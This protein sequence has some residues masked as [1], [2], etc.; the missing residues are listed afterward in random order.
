MAL[1]AGLCSV[2][3]YAAEKPPQPPVFPPAEDP[4]AKGVYANGIIESYLPNGENINIFPEVLGIVTQVAV[5]EGAKVKK[6][7]PLIILDSS[8]QTA[9]VAQQKAS[10]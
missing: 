2:Y 5:A 4:Y 6:G 3:L 7:T 1:W 9:T 8:I 10:A